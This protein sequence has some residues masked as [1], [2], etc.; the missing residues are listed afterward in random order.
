[1]SPTV[2]P[3]PEQPCTGSRQSGFS[4]VELM[5]AITLSLIILAA[6]SAIFVTSS[7]ARDEIARA[8]QQIEN[9]RY[10]MQI[11]SDDLQLAGY[12]G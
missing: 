1:M 3:S 11:L 9:G 5:I 12:Y 4:L 2:M 8:N 7:R 6:L 10:A